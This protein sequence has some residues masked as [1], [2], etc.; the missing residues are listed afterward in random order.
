MDNS[1]FVGI[2]PPAHWD[3]VTQFSESNR[4]SYKDIRDSRPEQELAKKTMMD[5]IEACKFKNCVIQ[6][7]YIEALGLSVR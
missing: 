1:A 6:K 4:A 3:L 5:F 7:S 2:T